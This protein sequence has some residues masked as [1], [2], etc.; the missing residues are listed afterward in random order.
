MSFLTGSHF[1]FTPS[2][3]MKNVLKK[4]S[5]SNPVDY[6]IM[7]SCIKRELNRFIGSREK[8]PTKIEIFKNRVLRKSLFKFSLANALRCCF[9]AT[10][11]M[12]HF[13]FLLPVLSNALFLILA[14][15]L[16]FCH[17]AK[18]LKITALKKNTCDA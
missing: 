5:Y 17:G 4:K 1:F 8:L 11:G 10:R 12:L 9:S 15:H 16:S 7:K 3:G 2:Q 6:P 14:S 18:T 13:F